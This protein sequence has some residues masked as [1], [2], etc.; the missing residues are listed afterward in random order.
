MCVPFTAFLM[1]KFK[2]EDDTTFR[3]ALSAKCND[4]SKMLKNKLKAA[5]ATAADP[6]S[7]KQDSQENSQQRNSQHSSDDSTA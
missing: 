6:S 1:K 7:Q 4:E 3:K 2:R 5:R